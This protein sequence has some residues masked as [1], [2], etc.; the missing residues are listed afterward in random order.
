MGLVV[1]FSEVARKKERF[2]NLEKSHQGDATV[3]IFPGVGIEYH[4][5]VLVED[6]P[7]AV[8]PHD[9]LKIDG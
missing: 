5:V 7:A 3:F 8:H 1:S 9:V 6:K 4:G 2:R